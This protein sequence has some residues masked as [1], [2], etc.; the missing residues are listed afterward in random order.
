MIEQALYQHLISR[1][2][3][4]PFLATYANKLAVFNQEAPADKED[5]KSV[6]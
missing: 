5:R 3:L 6:V 4:A 2:E 1:D